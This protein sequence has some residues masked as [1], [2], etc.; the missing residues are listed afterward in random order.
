VVSKKIRVPGLY[1]KLSE[2]N[3][4]MRIKSSWLAGAL[5]AGASSIMSGALLAAGPLDASLSLEKQI[6]RAAAESQKT[7]DSLAEQKADMAGEYKAALQRIDSLKAYNAQLRELVKSQ[8]TE[9]VSMK[10]EVISVDD[11]EKG[12]IPLMQ[13]MIDTLEQF[14]QLDAPFLA[15]E[16]TKRVAKLRTNMQRAD[17]SISEKYRQILE[18]YQIESDY[19]V[20]VS[21]YEGKIG[22]G[23]DE[24]TVRFLQMGRVAFLYQ[25]LDGNQAFVWDQSARD[26]T[27]L[28]GEYTAPVTEAIRV[29]A[30]Q[31][32][33]DLIKLPIFA[34]EAAQ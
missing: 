1:N 4:P 34:A 28:G 32:A 21:T 26:W 12:L 11:T 27:Q 8:E 23:G 16:R 9:K 13:Q 22:S 24:K 30:K 10:Q 19:G 6:S 33:P 25:T 31:A 14:V 7:I 5:V 3:M 15:D 29:A 2:T 17:I 20:S 18:A